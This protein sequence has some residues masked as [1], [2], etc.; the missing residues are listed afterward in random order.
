M[1]HGCCILPTCAYAASLDIKGGKIVQGPNFPW[2]MNEEVK[3]SSRNI[4]YIIECN[5]E[6]CKKKHIGESERTLKDRISELVSYIL[7]KKLNI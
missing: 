3:C 1:S 7:T 4:V 2:T 6:T 5:L